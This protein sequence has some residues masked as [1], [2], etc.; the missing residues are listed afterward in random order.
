MC[1]CACRS[2]S[3]LHMIINDRKFVC[4]IERIILEKKRLSCHPAENLK[5]SSSSEKFCCS[6]LLLAD[7]FMISAL[8]ICRC[9]PLLGGIALCCNGLILLKL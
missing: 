1:M 3:P 6:A 5:S 4:F 7:D 8:S 9:L 2:P